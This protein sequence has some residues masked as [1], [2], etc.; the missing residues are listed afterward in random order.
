MWTESSASIFERLP[1]ALRDTL[2]ATAESPL[3]LWLDG[4]C[5]DSI[6]LLRFASTFSS[7]DAFAVVVAAAA[8]TLIDAAEQE[9]A[10]DL[11][12]AVPLWRSVTEGKVSVQYL[13]S[14]AQEIFGSAAPS[15][16]I[17]ISEF[18]E[19]I[20]LG[21]ARTQAL[22]AASRR[23]LMRSALETPSKGLTAIAF[24]AL[25]LEASSGIPIDETTG[26]F[27]ARWA[28]E[29]SADI[30]AGILSFR[31]YLQN[32]RRVGVVGAL[33]PLEQG[34]THTMSVAEAAWVIAWEEAARANAH[35]ICSELALRRAN[36]MPLQSEDRY[37]WLIIHGLHEERKPA[38]AV[39]GLPVSREL[40][41]MMYHFEKPYIP[42]S[43]CVSIAARTNA[44]AP[45]LREAL[46]FLMGPTLP[47]LNAA[48]GV[49]DGPE[50]L[51]SVAEINSAGA[52]LA[53]RM[54]RAEERKIAQ[55]F[56]PKQRRKT[57]P[58]MAILDNYENNQ[59]FLSG[60]FAFEDEPTLSN[61]RPNEKK[62][63][64]N[65]EFTDAE[66][67]K[68]KEESSSHKAIEDRGEDYIQWADEWADDLTT[69]VNETPTNRRK[70]AYRANKPPA[71]H[72]SEIEENCHNPTHLDVALAG[73]L[74]DELRERADQYLAERIAISDTLS[75]SLLSELDATISTLP[76]SAWAASQ[77]LLQQGELSRAVAWMERIARVTS[78]RLERAARYKELGRLWSTQLLEPA[79]ALEYLIVAFT[80]EPTDPQTLQLLDD[81]YSHLKRFDDL[82][83]AYET[84]LESASLQPESISEQIRTQW[85]ER[86]AELSKNDAP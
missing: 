47:L 58:P 31:S 36:Q 83:I 25:D 67:P 75:H 85:T 65:H 44:L 41:D 72:S 50:D 17:T 55:G 74:P 18:D 81:S 73:S 34:D 53:L 22:D 61:A 5:H 45:V 27:G 33:T 63:Q 28:E 14:A 51:H 62:E 20:V 71:N 42:A 10:L 39:E 60:G 35:G 9:R 70:A 8:A 7:D 77:Y 76:N 12:Y 6:A 3:H 86:M 84:A 23:K 1:A 29:N 13:Q 57:P 48:F 43:L 38:R 59:D 80:C 78:N 37:R 16:A 52:L 64:S 69:S 82:R 24:F 46:P 2:S 11:T 54:H 15:P 66:T 32:A 68:R 40:L 79:Q 56:P 21:L 4:I 26:R 49:G 19:Y 30:D